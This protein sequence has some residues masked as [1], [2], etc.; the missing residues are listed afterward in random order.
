MMVSAM[1][2]RDFKALHI[3]VNATLRTKRWDASKFTSR[4]TIDL[5]VDVHACLYVVRYIREVHRRF[6]P[7]KVGKESLY[8]GQTNMLKE[9]NSLPLF[10]LQGPA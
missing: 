9:I 4:H 8:I 10:G 3:Y 7:F 6:V 2:L 1:T 5:L